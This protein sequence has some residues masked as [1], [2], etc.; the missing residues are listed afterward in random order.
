MLGGGNH[1]QVWRILVEVLS[2]KANRIS[3]RLQQASKFAWNAM[4]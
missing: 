4:I 2:Q 3:P 1:I